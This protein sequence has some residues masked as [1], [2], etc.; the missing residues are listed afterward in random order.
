MSTKSTLAIALSAL[1][2]GAVL[3][4]LLAPESGAATRKKLIKKGNDL[5]D[6]LSDLLDEGKDLVSE[7]KGDAQDAAKKVSNAAH[8]LKDQAKSKVEEV[9]GAARTATHANRN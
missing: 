4:V 1:A 5:K 3:G 2:A 8:D 7:L 9:A 6:S